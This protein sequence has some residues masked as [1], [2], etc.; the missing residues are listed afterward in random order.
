MT[1]TLC[2]KSNG[3][4]EIVSSA[5]ASLRNGDHFT[6]VTLACED[7]QQ[8]EAH[9]VIL[10]ASSPFFQ[11]LLERNNHPHPLIYMRMVTFEDL[12][13]IVDFIYFG[14]ANI[15][16]ENI[17]SFL[18]VA[19]ELQLKGLDSNQPDLDEPSL[20]PPI[21]SQEVA[22]HQESCKPSKNMESRLDIDPHL[23]KKEINEDNLF[24]EQ[25]FEP[26]YP[27]IY[28]ESALEEKVRTMLRKSGN[29]IKHGRH[30]QTAIMCTVC[31][32][33]GLST[34]I[35]NHIEVK[36]IKEGISIPCANCHLRFRSRN[37]LGKHKAK[38][39]V[40][41]RS[42]RDLWTRYTGVKEGGGG[43]GGMEEGARDVEEGAGGVQE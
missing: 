24:Q 2:L 7:G 32:K 34:H 17:E 4:Q 5:F 36:H 25:Y 9:R 40:Q 21:K 19:E 31:G 35:K 43:A 18:A 42:A 29:R 41:H 10:A 37:A 12:T 13:A 3:F 23:V 14:K 39:Q 28:D 11:K 6:D 38:H 20:E 1:E 33:E 30:T 16:Q 27:T 22:A 8:L 26:T 15:D